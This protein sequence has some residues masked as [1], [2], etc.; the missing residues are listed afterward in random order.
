VK[1]VHYQFGLTGYPLEYSL[2]PRIHMAALRVSNLQ[3]EYK[4]YPVP[5]MPQGQGDLIDLLDRMKVG[6]LHGLNVTI[7]HKQVIIPLLDGLTPPASAIGAVNAIY[8][9]G[10]KLIGDNTDASGF[11]TDLH[12]FF[13]ELKTSKR[14]TMALP[15]TA[16][17]L[18]AGGSAHAVVYALVK[19]GWRILVAARR[20]EQAQELSQSFARLPD[21]ETVELIP[22]L[23]LEQGA[24]RDVTDGISLIINTTPLG[25]A[26]QVNSS[27]WPSKVPFPPGAFVY[28]LVYNPP[29][30]ALVRAARAAGLPARTGLGM[31]VEQAALGFERWTGL[32]APRQAMWESVYDE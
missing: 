16:L 24:I 7:P 18:G 27:P 32:T 15:K 22:S 4:L 28:D 29:E 13:A 2:S 12:R 10:S 3:G 26:P 19:D 20:L 1:K 5:P 23:L 17:V 6:E 9:D 14:Y 11:K 21:G 30:T 8:Q 25:M 31:L